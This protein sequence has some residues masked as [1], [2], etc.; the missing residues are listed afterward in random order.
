MTRSVYFYLDALS[1]TERFEV[2]V[3]DVWAEVSAL[4][5][6][7]IGPRATTVNNKIFLLG[8]LVLFN[9]H[10]QL[11]CI[12][13]ILYFFLYIG[14]YTGGYL[15]NTNENFTSQNKI[16]EFEDDSWIEV[17]RMISSRYFHAVSTITVN[18]VLER[19]CPSSSS[20]HKLFSVP[21]F[22]Q[23]FYILFSK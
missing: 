2:E 7:L 12:L 18:Q 13:Y 21:L 15:N 3:S 9:K 6:D 23:L 8:Q 22:F 5:N 17:S 11:I 4:P 19:D 20:A 16:L 1:S 10:Y 14:G